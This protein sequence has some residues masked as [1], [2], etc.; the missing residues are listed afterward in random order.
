MIELLRDGAIPRWHIIFVAPDVHGFPPMTLNT[1]D[2]ADFQSRL[3][4]CGGRAG[5]AGGLVA[6]GH[7]HRR[8]AVQ[9]QHR[10]TGVAQGGR[11]NSPSISVR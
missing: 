11:R 7:W 3:G 1:S 9:S 10:T 4:D 8:A 2:L 5:E 6:I